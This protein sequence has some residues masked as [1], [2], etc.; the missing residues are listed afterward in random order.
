[1]VLEKTDSQM[2]KN[3]VGQLSYTINKNWLKWMKD[4]SVR[5]KIIKLLEENRGCKLLDIGVG[6]NFFLIW[7]Q[8]QQK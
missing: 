6:D 3:E 1:M 4:L 2:Q 8:K 7:Y 5:P